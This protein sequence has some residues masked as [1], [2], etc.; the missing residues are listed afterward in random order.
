LRRAAREAGVESRV[1]MLAPVADAAPLYRAA[2]VYVSA[3]RSE[4][5]SGSVLE[6]MA[7]GLPVVATRASGMAELLGEGRGVL[8]S[9]QADSGFGR[10][11]AALAADPARAAALGRAARA[12]AADRYSLESTADALAALYAAVLRPASSS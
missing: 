5:M 11:L 8:V 1:Q 7:S 3:S 2:D 12:R 10:A 9:D 6:A 4:G